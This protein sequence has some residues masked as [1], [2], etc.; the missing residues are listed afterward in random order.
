MIQTVKV[1]PIDIEIP[2]DLKTVEVGKIHSVVGMTVVVQATLTGDY[3]V[4]DAGTVLVLVDRRILGRVSLE[5]LL[6]L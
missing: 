1:E 4:L 3:Q 5:F 6:H 2:K